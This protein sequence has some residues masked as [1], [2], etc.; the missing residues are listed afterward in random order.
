MTKASFSDHFGKLIPFFRYIC[1]LKVNARVSLKVATICH[2]R[3]KKP[4]KITF[5]GY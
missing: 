4:K 3:G 1:Y 2:L 5:L